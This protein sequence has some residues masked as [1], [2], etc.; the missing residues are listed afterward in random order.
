MRSVGLLFSV[1]YF[2]AGT[3]QEPDYVQ[4]LIS[5]SHIIIGMVH[6]TIANP[7]IDAA[8]FAFISSSTP[9]RVK[10]LYRRAHYLL[11]PLPGNPKLSA[12]L[13]VSL[14]FGKHAQD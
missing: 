4:I 5:P 2:V 11:D 9:E 3:A 1:L 6:V 12:N 10:D 7:Q 8:P 13:R 14:A